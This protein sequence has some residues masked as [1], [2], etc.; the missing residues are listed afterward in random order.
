MTVPLRHLC[1]AENKLHPPSTFRAYN[2][3]HSII[4]NSEV[5]CNLWK[6]PYFMDGARYSG[7]RGRAG[8]RG[9]RGGGRGGFGRGPGGG[10]GGGGHTTAVYAPPTG[11]R[12]A[13]RGGRGRGAGGRGRGKGGRGNGPVP[14]HGDESASVSSGGFAGAKRPLDGAAGV[15]DSSKKKKRHHPRHGKYAV[16]NRKK[17]VKKELEREQRRPE[18]G[19][20]VEAKVIWNKLR[21]H[22]V[23]VLA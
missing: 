3:P 17:R 10:G 22:Q 12:G 18:Y 13:G 7:G 14:S 9:G 23:G 19:T 16:A 11:G 2:A 8:G 15:Q 5:L 20:V 21:E 1:S 6:I 4:V